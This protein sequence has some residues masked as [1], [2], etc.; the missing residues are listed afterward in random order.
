[1][2]LVCDKIVCR[3]GG[4]KLKYRDKMIPSSNLLSPKE[5][6]ECYKE[7]KR[8]RLAEVVV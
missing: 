5:V 2:E 6:K 4:L 8:M 7:I 1:M 3:I